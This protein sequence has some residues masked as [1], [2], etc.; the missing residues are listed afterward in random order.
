MKL[1]YCIV[2][3]KLNLCQGK[4]GHYRIT[5]PFW[6]VGGDTKNRCLVFQNKASSRYLSHI[7]VLKLI[8]SELSRGPLSILDSLYENGGGKQYMARP[9]T[10]VRNS[11]TKKLRPTTGKIYILALEVN[12]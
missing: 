11:L 12:N 5:G 3:E 9:L 10:E 1:A 6:L 4:I 8:L 2:S 7:Y